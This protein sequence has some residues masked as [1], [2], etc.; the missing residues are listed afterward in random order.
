MISFLIYVLVHILYCRNAYGALTCINHDVGTFLNHVMGIYGI[1]YE[2]HGHKTLGFVRMVH[3]VE[4][5]ATIDGSVVNYYNF[6]YFWLYI[7]YNLEDICTYGT[8]KR[9]CNEKFVFVNV[10]NFTIWT[11]NFHDLC[12]YIIVHCVSIS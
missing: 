11:T 12:L 3:F 9:N 10:V 2:C 1:M 7:W 4:C 5:P 8:R 6:A